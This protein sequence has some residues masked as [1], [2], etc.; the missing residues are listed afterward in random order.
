MRRRRRIVAH[1]VDAREARP[2]SR[3][4]DQ[5]RHGCV[6]TLHERLDSAVGAISHP[7]GEAKAS[8]L[9]A[10][11]VAK[12]YALHLATDTNLPRSHASPSAKC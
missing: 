3:P 6:I 10:Q 7:A 8:R 5:S 12:T 2:A 9:V 4:C 11:R 1:V